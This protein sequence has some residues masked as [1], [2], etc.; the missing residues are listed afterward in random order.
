MPHSGSAEVVGQ[1]SP[2]LSGAWLLRGLKKALCQ[3]SDEPLNSRIIC[4]WE[5][6]EL[7]FLH[8]MRT[9]RAAACVHYFSNYLLLCKYHPR[10]EDGSKK[11]LQVPS[12]LAEMSQRLQRLYTRHMLQSLTPLDALQNSLSDSHDKWNHNL[13][14]PLSVSESKC[15]KKV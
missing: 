10:V 12:L 4:K 13:R 9:S 14:N 3:G 7:I 11:T 15:L 8:L 1:H 5:C 6:W 2:V